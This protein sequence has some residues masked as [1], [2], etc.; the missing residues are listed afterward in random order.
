MPGVYRLP[1]VLAC[2]LILFRKII[3][4]IQPSGQAV[5]QG[6]I[7]D[8][9]RRPGKLRFS[10]GQ[11]AASG[12]GRP[13]VLARLGGLF[14]HMKFSCSS[15]SP[16]ARVQ[17]E[18]PD[19]IPDHSRHM[20]ALLDSLK[21]PAADAKAQS[22]IARDLTRLSKRLQDDL[23]ALPG[24]RQGLSACVDELAYPDLVV[25][26]DGA[27]GYPQIHEAV[28]RRISPV[29]L[30]ARAAEVLRQ[31]ETAMNQRL[32]EYVVREP[33]ARM[34]E[35]LTSPDNHEMALVVELRRLQKAL[36]VLDNDRARG[37]SPAFRMVG[38]YLQSLSC[39]PAQQ[40]LSALR[41]ERLDLARNDL[42]RA[43][44]G[45][46]AEWARGYGS[47]SM[48]A[49]LRLAVEREIHVRVQLELSP[50]QESLARMA[51]LCDSR[52]ASRFLRDLYDLVDQRQRNYGPLPEKTLKSVR[53]LD[54]E[55][56]RLF[57]HTS[58]NPHG[59]LNQSSLN[60]LDDL[61]LSR[62]CKLA[63]L[64]RPLE[65]ELDLEAA[66]AVALQRVE[67]LSQ[68]LIEGIADVF[69]TL[70]AAA[71]DMPVLVR[72]LR[73]LSGVE[74]QRIQRLMEL[75][76]FSSGGPGEN[77]GL[78]MAQEACRRAT[79]K[80]G[81]ISR[82][83]IVR[84][85]MRHLSLLMGLEGEFGKI[86]A[87]LTSNVDREDGHLKVGKLLG[88]T[89]HLLSGMI[90]EMYERLP[91]LLEIDASDAAID[92]CER[93]L[94]LLNPDAAVLALPGA[95]CQALREQYGVVHPPV[96]GADTESSVSNAP[97]GSA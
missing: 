4:H 39:E 29:E 2:G 6:P 36:T 9:A 8:T 64:V 68:Q 54:D 91:A 70:S 25:L 21:A 69:R 32:A 93:M 45:H 23:S 56:L 94:A 16:P 18:G 50:F 97:G 80:L 81:G 66:K 1:T 40:V 79:E 65:L 34:V 20:R 53:D 35:L 14:A 67:P 13:G 38:M 48:L 75:G 72:Q 95:F 27:L 82:T 85:A 44:G 92:L 71:V 88:A 61:T 10:T 31:M 7:P 11:G 30:R 62:L 59:P 15:S 51:G 83:S 55:S 3:M 90:G 60:G 19:Q 37:G 63:R 26:R 73:D 86:A 42:M 58:A 22:R 52:A 24:G 57:R 12:S 46:D 5:S 28:L 77:E 49:Y 41:P 47:A 87:E 76:Q 17:R 43:F 78:A 84:D 96:N 74:L 89:R 33:V